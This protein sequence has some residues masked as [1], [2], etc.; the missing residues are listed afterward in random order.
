M[1][2]GWNKGKSGGNQNTH[3]KA[4]KSDSQR[5]ALSLRSS[6]AKCCSHLNAAL[7]LLFLILTSQNRA[8]CVTRFCPKVFQVELYPWHFLARK[9]PKVCW[10]R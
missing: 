7:S 5:L 6:I 4:F 2:S 9:F 1:S 8:K 3:N 10:A